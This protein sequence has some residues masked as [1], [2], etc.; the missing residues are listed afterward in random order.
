MKKTQ[1]KSDSQTHL[2]AKDISPRRKLFRRLWALLGTLALIEFSWL[3]GS[4]LYARKDAVKK[5]TKEKFI[6]AG[7]AEAFPPNSVTPIPE[8]QFYLARLEDGSFLALSQTCTHLDCALPWDVNEQKFICPCHGSTFD[9]E[10]EVLTP[11]ATRGLN[12]YPLYV[13]NGIIR[14]NIALSQKHLQNGNPRSVKA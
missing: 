6:T 14:V 9:I 5:D 3:T 1:H 2:T 11:P 7:K 8:G 4:I 12:S 13:E 10:G